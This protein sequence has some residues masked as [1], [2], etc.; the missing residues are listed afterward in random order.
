MCYIYPVSLI[1]YV[2]SS[3]FMSLYYLNSIK[4]AVVSDDDDIID[5]CVYIA[6]RF[7]S[8]DM[9][10]GTGIFAKLLK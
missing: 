8:L 4:Y 6:N 2:L 3:C 9:E 7:L 10:Q 5:N 1:N